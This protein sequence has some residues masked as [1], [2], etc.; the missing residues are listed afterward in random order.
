MLLAATAAAVALAG[1]GGGDHKPRTA[2][3]A[4]AVNLQSAYNRVVEAVSPSVVQITTGEGLGSGVVLDTDGNI[5]T[6]A[7]VVGDA[8]RFRVTLQSGKEVDATL[9]GRWTPGDLAVVRADA[10]GLKP[11]AIADSSKLSVGDIVMAIGNPLGLR[12]SVTQGIVSSLGRTVSEGASGVTIGS[13]IQTSAAIN[14]GNSGGALVD[15]QGRLIGIPTLAATDPQLGGGAAPGIG[16]AIPS[17]TVKSI[18]RQLIDHGSVTESGRASLGIRA[19][20]VT[21]GGVVIVDVENGGPAD[22]AGLRR[23]EIILSL[24]GQRTADVNALTTELATLEPG[25]TVSITV[26]GADGRR[27]ERKVTLG[28]LSG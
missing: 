20:T 17:D 14:P 27:H 10:T 26:A 18:S 6:N 13:A 23:G 7:H 24:D 11:A 22:R 25:Q 19:A 4:P 28:E 15:L 16:F 8:Q 5:V 3:V 12:S 1:C 9:V 21:G 2:G